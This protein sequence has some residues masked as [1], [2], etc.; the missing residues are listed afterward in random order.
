LY[1]YRL[2]SPIKKRSPDK[3]KSHLP[4]KVPGKAVSPFLVPQWGPY[5]MPVLR[6]FLYISF[7]VSR[8]R[9]LPQGSPQIPTERCSISRALFYCLLKSPV[10]ELPLQVPQWGLYGKRCPSPEPSFIN[11]SGLPVEEPSLRVPL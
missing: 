1:I 9:A 5:E 10:N 2:D 7:R 11:L 6:A 3:S 4:L 8:K